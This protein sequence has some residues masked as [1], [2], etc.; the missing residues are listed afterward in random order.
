MLARDI[1]RFAEMMTEWWAILYGYLS[2]FLIIPAIHY[3]D[4]FICGSFNGVV[5]ESSFLA[6]KYC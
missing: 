2:I 4:I 6:S 5:S 3:I 1:K